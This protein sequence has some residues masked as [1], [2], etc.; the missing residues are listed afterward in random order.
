MEDSP[1]RDG[2]GKMAVQP[3]VFIISRTQRQASAYPF[4][5]A[6][7]YL[8]DYWS[9]KTLGVPLFL[10]IFFFFREGAIR[11]TPYR[12][13]DERSSSVL[14]FIFKLRQNRKAWKEKGIVLPRHLE[15]ERIRRPDAS[16]I[17]SV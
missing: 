13:S 15:L 6:A 10:N 17:R 8:P 2:D 12:I 16:G 3:L 1:L 9:E 11:P 4:F 14:E 5:C 7:T